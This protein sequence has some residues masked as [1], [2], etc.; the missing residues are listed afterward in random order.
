M[1]KLTINKGEVM[2]VH[3]N[4]ILPILIQFFMN[5]NRWLRLEFKPF[6]KEVANHTGIG[7]DT[8][9]VFE[10]VAKGNKPLDINSHYYSKKGYVIKVYSFDFNQIQLDHLKAYYELYKDIPYQYT[11]FFVWIVNILTL[12]FVWIGRTGTDAAKE[13]YCSE[14]TSTLLYYM[15]TPDLAILSSH[16]KMHQKLRRFWRVSPYDIQKICEQYGTLKSTYVIK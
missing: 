4:T 10:A 2:I 16:K 7:V 15:T 13:M 14:T 5:L 11:N 3:G 12:G 6:Y 9:I 1:E 8:D